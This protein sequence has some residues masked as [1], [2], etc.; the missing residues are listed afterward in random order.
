MMYARTVNRP[1][2]RISQLKTF[3]APIGG[4]IKNRALA[5]PNE[6]DGPPGAEVLDNYIP[7]STSVTLRRGKLRYCTLGD[8][9]EDAKSLFSYNTATVKKLFGA[10]E[11]T[12]YDITDVEFA[13]DAEIVDENGARIVT[14][15]GDWFGWSSTEFL[16]VLTGNTGGN[17]VVA[18]FATTGGVYLVGV[19]GQ[20]T[21]FIYDGDQFYPYVEGGS[22]TLDYDTETASF[23]AGQTLTGG[24]SL[25][26]ATIWKV[27]DNGATGTLILTNLVGGPFQNN[28]TITDGLGGSAL[29]NGASA[30]AVPGVAFDAGITSADMSFVWVYKNRLYFAQ[31]DTMTAWYLDVDSIAGTAN[32]FPLSGVFGLGGTLLFG[33]AW[34]LS[35][36]GAGG[37]NE[38][39]VFVSSEGEVA[40]YQGLYPGDTNSWAKVGTYRI[41]KPLGNRAFIRGGG[42]LAI[43][44]SIGLI[45]LSKA[46]E[47]DLT[48][49]SVAAISNR[50]TDAWA[51]AVDQRGLSDWQAELWPEQ[52]LA[53]FAPPDISGNSSPVMFIANTE[54]GSWSRFTNWQGLCMDVFEGRL[55]FGE[56]AGK[57]FVGLETGL[58]DGEPYTGAVM[59]LFDDLGTPASIKIGKVGRAVTRATAIVSG[60]VNWRGDFNVTLPPVP[61]ATELL[62][63]SVWDAGV[64]GTSAWS[65][66]LPQVINDNWR[67]IG[68]TGYAVSLVYQVT[69][70]SPQPLDDELI[71]FDMVFDT[72]D[73]IS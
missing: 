3:P 43:A 34:S 50:I 49:L 46:V 59:P 24:T 55:F 38:Q 73:V 29:A 69:S 33:N 42:D 41:G 35:N 11:T 4:W 7:R 13:E 15:S 18:Q 21:G 19:N 65:S 61:D 39:N 17:W 72:A 71:R 8:G 30:I 52:K 26:T 37:L 25:A 20:D 56:P 6:M 51:D 40:V 54:T 1:K 66:G 45:P 23:T 63:S 32:E 5:L 10:T 36:E 58:D 60:Q 68:G 44:T 9:S 31:T 64:W 22:Y 14:T 70:G 53:L 48:A 2:Q 67:S 62:S 28:E 27:I 57:V 47:L 12:I 16:D